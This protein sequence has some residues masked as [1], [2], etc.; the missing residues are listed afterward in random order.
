MAPS[1][2][3]ADGDAESLLL[4][5]LEAQATGRPVV[6]TDHGGIPEFVRAGETALVVPE[7]DAGALADAIV[8]LLRDDALAE[9]LAAAGPEWAARFDVSGCV[10]RVDEVY[11]AVMG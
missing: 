6:T 8:T 9:R 11:D 3:T 2:T 4:V 7:A 10:A 1:R 5:N